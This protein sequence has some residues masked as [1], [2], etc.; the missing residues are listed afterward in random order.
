MSDKITI[1]EEYL[2]Q[3]TDLRLY[4]Y[5]T[6]RGIEYTACTPGNTKQNFFDLDQHCADLVSCVSFWHPLLLEFKIHADDKLPSFKPVQHA[7]LQVLNDF[8]IPVQY[9]FNKNPIPAECSDDVFLDNLLVCAAK[10]LPGKKPHL[11]HGSL[12]EMINQ[13]GTGAPPSLTPFAICDSGLFPKQ[14]ISQLNTARLLVMSL[15]KV[16]SLTV[17]QGSMLINALLSDKKWAKNKNVVRLQQDLNSLRQESVDLVNSLSAV[18]WKLEALSS[19]TTLDAD[20]SSDGLVS[21]D[22]PRTPG[23]RLGRD[24]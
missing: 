23:S 11:T 20:S 18:G 4:K 16:S 14:R 1:E 15:E 9:C 3:E 19:D 5:F 7:G 21:E 2:V 24:W 17:E 8:G 6:S 12:F 22:K 13:V 10:P